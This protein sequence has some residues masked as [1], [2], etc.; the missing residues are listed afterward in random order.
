MTS[1]ITNFNGLASGIQWNDVV[2]SIVAAEEARN[3]TPIS[4]QLELRGRQQEAWTRFRGLTDTLNDKARAVRLAGFGGFRSTVP[5][6]PTSGATLLGAA[7]S[8]QASPGRY[9]VEVQQLAETAKFSSQPVA[10]RNAALESVGEFAI[11]GTAIAIEATDSLMTI[12]DKINAANTG[13]T[14]TGV[15]ATVNNEGATGGRLILTRSTPGSGDLAVTTDVT[16]PLARDLGYVSRSHLATSTTTAIAASLG[17]SLVPPPATIR[18]DGRVITV[19][20]ETES[21]AAIVAKINAAGG[22]AGT[23]AVAFGDET[24]F[25]LVV[26]GTV[27]ANPGDSNSQA[28]IDALGM[29][30]AATGKIRQ[31]AVTGIYTDSVG[32]L[33]TGGTALAGLRLDGASVGLAVGDAINVRG[34][35]GDGSTFTVGL[36]VEAGD[37]MDDLLARVNDPATGLGAGTRPA[38][39]L[40][41]DDGRLRVVDSVSGASRLGLELDIVRAN[42]STGSLGRTSAETTGRNLLLQEGRDAIIRVDGEEY[43]RS[44]NTITDVI[45]NVTL[46]LATAEPGTEV[47]LDITRDLDGAAESMQ[48]LVTA[49]NAVRSFFDEQ[50]QPDAPLYGNSLMRGVVDSFTSALRTEATGNTTY[51][52]ATLT[53]VTLDRNGGLTFDSS[54]FKE[55]LGAAPTE[56]EA[57]FG[58]TGIGGALV[59]AT[60]RATAF[61]NGTISNQLNSILDSTQRLQRQESEARRRL[62]A[63]RAALVAQFTEMETALSRLNAQSAS[64][65]GLLNPAQNSR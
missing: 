47:D 23:E 64:L 60:D 21:L 65:V 34:T 40:I 12:R 20:L 4:T 37:T 53:G 63:R 41:G 57:L 50:R 38:T 5:T 55:A 24:R 29:A 9:R 33:A 1:P 22:S 11:N 45:P 15:I 54:K 52:R 18:V 48:E 43:V 61:G 13:A 17:I 25:Q 19:N 14:P 62:E 28:V 36:V 10:D 58:F 30:G 59:S 31:V 26:D 44:T 3:V 42:G 6:S 39:A 51:N 56:I 8:S 2:D 49:Y 7:A 35:R 16:G 27:S 32:G 46:S